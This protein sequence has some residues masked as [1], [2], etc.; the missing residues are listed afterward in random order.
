MLAQEAVG[1]LLEERRLTAHV[2]TSRCSVGARTRGACP[3]IAGPQSTLNRLSNTLSHVL[4]QRRKTS[5]RVSFIRD[6]L[7]T[8]VTGL[9]ILSVV[10]MAERPTMRSSLGSHRGITSSSERGPV[11]PQ[12]AHATEGGSTTGLVPASRPTRAPP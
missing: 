7:R 3:R 6:C 2:A 5:R 8:I 1:V 10:R 4:L 12:N 11:E 9:P